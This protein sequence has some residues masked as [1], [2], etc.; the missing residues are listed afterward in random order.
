MVATDMADGAA[1]TENGLPG[2]EP[3]AADQEDFGAVTVQW[4][5]SIPGVLR[6]VIT[7]LGGDPEAALRRW[8]YNF[9]LARQAGLRKILVVLDLA[10]PLIPEPQLAWMIAQVAEADVG[11]F[12][13]AIVQ[14]RDARRPH[15]EVGILIAIEHDITAR[16]FADESSALVWL[17]YGER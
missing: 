4:D 13:V 7:G 16:V 8:R 3:P 1:P 15:D 12:R 5:R 14:L 17:R 6:V 9:N 2:G 10:G 11:D